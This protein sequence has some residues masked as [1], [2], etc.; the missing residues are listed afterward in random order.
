MGEEVEEEDEEG[1]EGPK[2]PRSML[3]LELSDGVSTVK[4]SSG[5]D[6]FSEG[7]LADFSLLYTLQAIE[8]KPIPTLKLGETRLGTKVSS[9]RRVVA[10]TS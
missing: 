6:R 8:R 1:E 4:A 10:S 2:Y 9:P 7:S 3:K 5:V